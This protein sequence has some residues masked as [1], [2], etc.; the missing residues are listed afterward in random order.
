MDHVFTLKSLID[1][2][3]HKKK[4]LFC[5][6]VDFKK[7][8][9]TVWRSG[10]WIKLISFGITGKL[11]N[12]IRNIYN[13]IKSCVQVNGQKS[14][15]FSCYTGVRQGGNLSPLLFALYLNDLESF[16]KYNHVN[17]LKLNDNIFDQ[18]L[19]IQILLYADDTVLLSD[20]ADGLQYSLN[21]LARYCEHWKLQVNT[22]KTE[23]VIFSKGKFKKSY[24]FTF[25]NNKV[26]IVDSFKYL[27]VYFNYNGSFIYHK[28][29]IFG[30]AQKA[31]FALL[32]KSKEL[33]LPVDIQLELFDYLVLPILIYGC[34]I[35]GYENISILDK[36][37]LKFLK[38]I[39]CL[40]QST[41]TCMVLGETGR[42]PL[43]IAIKTRMI[44]FWCKL[45]TSDVNRLSTTLYNLLQIYNVNNIFTSKWLQYI[46][47]ILDETGFSYIWTLQEIPNINTFP[48]QIKQTLQDQYI[49]QWSANL[50]L[51]NKCRSYR[52]FKLK[53]ELEKY[54]CSLSP[55]NRKIICR[56]RTSNHRLPIERGRFYGI[57][58]EDRTCEFCNSDKI[59]DEFH[60]VLE[61]N[62]LID[63]RQTFL[64]PYCQ[65]H[66][67]HIKFKNIM[68][69]TSSN[70]SNE[71]AK[72][73]KAAFKFYNIYI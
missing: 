48:N 20:N 10:L 41:P 7:T 72:Y 24:N 53:F 16:L 1:I 8:F 49:H 38:Y 45:I 37:H 47:T 5:A 43:S 54:L 17:N 32:K 23:I 58:R 11:F 34:K 52:I 31:F 26:N 44:S 50:N 4:K 33:E 60:F 55:F 42:V 65:N 63:I 62:T 40:K 12:V 71:L 56:F 19:K 30:Q 14:D 51:S 36:L 64:P 22:S 67:N 2:F 3:L 59:C 68:S 28:K 35:W 25:N 46:K 57:N 39:L 15:Y 9:D 73:L 18:F 21:C 69:D 61:C 13:N 29:F 6:F 70:I 66:P 27:G